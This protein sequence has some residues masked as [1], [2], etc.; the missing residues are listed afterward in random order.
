MVK[1][2]YHNTNGKAV[3]PQ[4]KRENSATTTQTYVRSTWILHLCRMDSRNWNPVDVGLGGSQPLWTV[5]TEALWMWDWVAHSHYGHDKENSS[6]AT[7]SQTLVIQSAADCFN[8]SYQTC[9]VNIVLI[10]FR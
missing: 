2:C 3:L 10:V 5:E 1:Q 9:K 7:G 6:A 4:H 8:D